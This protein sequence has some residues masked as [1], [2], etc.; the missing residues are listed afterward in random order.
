MVPFIFVGV[1][2]KEKNPVVEEAIAA[3]RG[4]G[5][6]KPIEGIVFNGP[7]IEPTAP[8]LPR[9]IDDEGRPFPQKEID[10]QVDAFILRQSLGMLTHSLSMAMGND[11]PTG[12]TLTLEATEA[13][14]KA[15]GY[16][17]KRTGGDFVVTVEVAGGSYT[18]TD[19]DRHHAVLRALHFMALR[20][21]PDST[22][23]I[24]RRLFAELTKRDGTATAEGENTQVH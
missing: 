2:V 21:D 15:L 14:L 10:R 4:L 8:V 3:A 13:H 17:V 1:I 6:Q 12:Y 23:F 19:T 20:H 11:M 7:G 16:V 18:I 22:E 9:A 24:K 5:D